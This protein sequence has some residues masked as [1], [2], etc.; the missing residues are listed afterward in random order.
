[1]NAKHK[2]LLVAV[3]AVA[4][5]ALAQNQTPQTPVERL[6]ALETEVAGL[7]SEIVL[8][9]QAAGNAD[10]ASDVAASRASIAALESWV[11]AQSQAAGELDRALAE[12]REKGFT[13]GIT[14]DSREVLLQ[15]FASFTG[16][17]H[18]DAFNPAPVAPPAKKAPQPVRPK[19]KP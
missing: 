19:S 17:V 18:T 4:G 2:Y 3:A 13:Y 15:G 7:K 11:R 12:A 14:P 10:L 8:L 5:L 6:A 1:M 16:A 9:K